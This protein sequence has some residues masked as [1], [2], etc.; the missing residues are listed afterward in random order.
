MADEFFNLD[1]E[2]V[3]FAEMNGF[4]FIS[5]KYITEKSENEMYPTTLKYGT[6][7]LVDMIKNM[8]VGEKVIEE[9]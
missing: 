4:D 9:K 5:G 3:D 1:E 2:L 6:F 8:F 7:E